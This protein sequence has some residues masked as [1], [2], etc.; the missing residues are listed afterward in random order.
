MFKPLEA[1]LSR[2]KLNF[3][4]HF[5][6]IKKH[7]GMPSIREGDQRELLGRLIAAGPPPDAFLNTKRMNKK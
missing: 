7:V 5:C 6:Q 1:A 4:S 2:F 3:C